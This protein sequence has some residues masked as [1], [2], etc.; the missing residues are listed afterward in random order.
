MRGGRFFIVKIARRRTGIARPDYIQTLG[1]FPNLFAHSM[2]DYRLHGP[3][4]RSK[5]A[6][7]AFFWAAPSAT[8]VR[9]VLA[10]NWKHWLQYTA[11]ELLLCDFVYTFRLVFKCK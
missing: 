11:A 6:S 1:V 7:G 10:T 2:G 4:K 5:S 8:S 9:F 3:L